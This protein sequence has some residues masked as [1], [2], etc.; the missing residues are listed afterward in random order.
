M[1]KLLILAAVF[2]LLTAS[3]CLAEKKFLVID[4]ME[5]EISG[6]PNGTVDFGAGNGSAVTVT[7]STDIMQ[8]GKQAMKVDYDSVDGGYMWIARGSGLDAKNSKW[9]VDNKTIDWGKYEAISFYMY[10]T[11]S[12]KDVAFD[13]K[14]N[15]GEIF[16]FIVNDN[17]KG[18]KQIIC[19]FD[20]FYARDDWQPE[21]AE[22]NGTMDFPLKSYQFE[23]KG[24]GKGTLYFDA[25]ALIEK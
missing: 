13:V 23:P 5:G 7:A 9:D 4:D 11:D 24:A 20:K 15:G 14:D 21:S 19:A 3:V 8:S 12:K 16:R 25:V 22:K 18:W 2:V 1:K 17:F 6:I 10:G